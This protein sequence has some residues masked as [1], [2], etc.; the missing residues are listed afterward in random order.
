MKKLKKMINLNMKVKDF[1]YAGII[2]HIPAYAYHIQHIPAYSAYTCI[3]SMCLHIQHMPA[4]P[5][6]TCI[7]L[8]IQKMPAPAYPAYTPML[9]KFYA[10]TCLH[11]TIFS[12]LCMYTDQFLLKIQVK[13]H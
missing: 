8:H 11:I 4:Y 13:P 10:S 3:F 7:C 5:A 6:Y 1:F 12:F 9:T 2:G